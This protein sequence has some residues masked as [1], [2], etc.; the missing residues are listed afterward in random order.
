MRVE[1]T[2]ITLGVSLISATNGA[3]VTGLTNSS[4]TL[5]YWRQGGSP[6]P[7]VASPLDAINSAHSD[8]AFLEASSGSMPG[9]YRLDV[10][11]AVW[12]QGA[13]W[14]IVEVHAPTTAGAKFRYAL[15]ED[16]LIRTG[17]AQAGAANTITLDANASDDTQYYRGMACYIVDGAGIGQMRAIASYATSTKVAT[18][19]PSWNSNPGSDSVFIVSADYGPQSV[20]SYDMGNSRIVQESLFALRNRVDMSSSVGTVFATNDSTSAYTFDV[21]R[22]NVNTLTEVDPA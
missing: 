4:V 20:L 14:A 10:P 2:D 18:V 17:T 16:G 11:D 22:A 3:P 21:T 7:I 13:D 9:T 19:F 8:G 1:E 6:T 15:V 5:T 12:A